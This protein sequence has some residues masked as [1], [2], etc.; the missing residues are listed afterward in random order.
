MKVF[1]YHSKFTLK[2][3]VTETANAA[4]SNITKFMNNG[5][6]STKRTSPT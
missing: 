1:F 6:K 4:A 3:I 5:S 2:E